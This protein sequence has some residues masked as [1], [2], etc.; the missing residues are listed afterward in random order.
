MGRVDH[1]I[2]FIVEKLKQMLSLSLNQLLS[3][4]EANVVSLKQMLSL[5]LLANDVSL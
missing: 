5:F 2:K 4:P 3:L 1:I